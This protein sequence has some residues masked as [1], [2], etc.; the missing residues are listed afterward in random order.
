MP[1]ADAFVDELRATIDAGRVFGRH[2]LWLRIADGKVPRASLGPFVVQFF[3]QVR[4]FP[5]AVSA[6]HS[7][8]P[9]GHERIELAESLYEEETG[10]ISGCNV[11]HPELF[12]RFGESV[13][14]PRAAMVDGTPLPST[15]ALIAWFEASTKERS[16][17]EG[18]AA[19]NL[20]AEGQVPG[21]F[22]PFARALERH[23]GCTP[24]EVAFWD[25]HE[26]ADREHSAIG[27][28]VVVRLATTPALQADVRGSVERSLA[29]WKGFFDGIATAMGTA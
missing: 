6:L 18:A 29:L 4:E 8:C 11:S 24:A 22:G 3:L 15:A 28:H 16:F 27:D 25:V 10:R 7:S 9:D 12:I 14:V 17:I 21:A 13:G 1:A 23:Y 2:P 5:R 19:T 20:A 26:Q